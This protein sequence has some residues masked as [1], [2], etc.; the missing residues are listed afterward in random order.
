MKTKKPFIQMISTSKNLSPENNIS[1]SFFF[2]IG[3]DKC[4]TISVYLVMSIISIYYFLR[5]QYIRTAHPESSFILFE[6]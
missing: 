2:F 6:S 5:C 4:F 1:K 3:F